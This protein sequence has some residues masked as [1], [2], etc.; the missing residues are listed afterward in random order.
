MAYVA[1]YKYAR[2]EGEGAG[3]SCISGMDEL[4]SVKTE[5][6]SMAVISPSIEYLLRNS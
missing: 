2:I 4:L 5:R 3:A 6:D 1:K